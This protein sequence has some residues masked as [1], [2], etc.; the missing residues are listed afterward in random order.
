MFYGV[1]GA[2]PAFEQTS[3][4]ARIKKDISNIKIFMRKN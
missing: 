4:L 3:G 1:S 2:I